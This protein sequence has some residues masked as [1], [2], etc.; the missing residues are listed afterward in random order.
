[1]SVVMKIKSFS[2]GLIIVKITFLLFFTVYAQETKQELKQVRLLSVQID[3]RKLLMQALAERQST[4][5][6]SSEPLSLQMLS[7][8]LWAANGINRPDTSGRTAPSAMNMQEI[9][10]YV[11]KA[12]GLF[13]YDAKDNALLQVLSE[14]IRA[15]TGKQEF[16]KDAPVNLIFVADFTK[17]NKIPQEEVVFYAACDTGFVSQNVY[18]FCASN[19]LATVVRGWIDKTALAKA[20]K[21]K[22]AQTIILAQTVGYPKKQNDDGRGKVEEKTI[23]LKDDYQLP[24]NSK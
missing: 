10:I 5:E 19:A 6:F 21:L 4:R 2:I 18:L 7:D 17:M 14:D 9:D 15:L 1:M 11:A 24:L 23:E 22:P 20:M 8:L 13:L 12:D 16:V 3:N